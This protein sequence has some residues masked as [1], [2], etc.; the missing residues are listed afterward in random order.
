ML[1]LR[2]RRRGP[3]RR[4]GTP[5]RALSRRRAARVSSIRAT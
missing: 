4:L 2:T 3:R 5:L 1:R